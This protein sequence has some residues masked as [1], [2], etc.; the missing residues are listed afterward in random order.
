MGFEATWSLVDIPAD[1]R[2]AAQAAA[3]REGLSVGE[4]L[5]RRILR[6]FSELNAREQA[7]T[8]V[9]LRN[10]V[11]EL[12]GRLDRFEGQS[13]AEPMREALKKL[14][15]GLARL[16]DELV[17]TAGHSAI[18]VSQLSTSLET[19]NVRM[20]EF[21]Q[22]DAES[23]SA[24]ERR[25]SQL[26][27]FVDGMN[28]RHAAETRT[29]ASRMDSLGGTLAESRRLIASD[30]AV[31]ERL[32]DSQAKADSRYSAAFRSLDE[33]IG[34]LS[35]RVEQIG[36]ASS[37]SS[38]AVEHQIAS[39]QMELGKSEARHT[40][41]KQLATA[42]LEKLHGKVDNLQNDMTGMCGALD[43]RV[44]L[45]QQA[46]QSLDVRH[47]EMAHSLTRGLESVGAQLD[48][49]RSDSARI[50]ADVEK[51]IATLETA[52]S[53]DTD[54]NAETHSRFVAIENQLSDLAART[55]AAELA[56][57][58]AL[59]KTD[60]IASQ[61]EQLNLKF[62]TEVE[63]QQQAVEQ[64]RAS[65]VEQTLGALG[66]KLETESKKQ[67]AAIAEL[68]D[69]LLMDLSQAF[70]ERADEEQHKQQDAMTQLQSAFE[71]ALHD[72]GETFESEARKQ[73]EAIAELKASLAVT[74][75][76]SVLLA[77]TDEA[78]ATK[79]GTGTAQTTASGVFGIDST[80]AQPTE[81]ETTATRATA[82]HEEP[83]LEL[84]VLAD[85]H[86]STAE[87]QSEHV[88]QSV[89]EEESEGLTAHEGVVSPSWATAPQAETAFEPA[90][91]TGHQTTAADEP[92]EPVPQAEA[93]PPPFASPEARSHEIPD[94]GGFRPFASASAMAATNASDAPLSGASYLSAARQSLQ[95]AA[96]SNEP[97]KSGKELPGFRFLRSL[98]LAGKQT[99]H[100]TS[101]ALIAGI[102]LV[103]IV[104]VSV[105]VFELTS[106]TAP[107]NNMY[108]SA[109]HDAKPV[110]LSR[111]SHSARMTLTPHLTARLPNQDRVAALANGGD[112]QAQLNIGLRE[113]AKGDNTGAAKWLERA[114]VQGVPPAE[115]RLATLYAS[116]HGVA[117]DRAKAFRWYLEAAQAGNRKAMSNLAVAYAQGD[118][119]PKNPQE[120]GRWFLKAAQL[121]LPDAQFDLAILY[122][123]GLGVPQNLTDAYRW[124]VI[125]AKAG[126][127]ESKDRVD[128]L[129]S[130]LTVEDRAAAEAAAS[131]FKPLPMNVRANEP[132]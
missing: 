80:H 122:E 106:R 33:N 41:E 48:M 110:K 2:D 71:T 64:L 31:V 16:N 120:A 116:G 37:E 94:L 87:I 98:P 29:I 95:T 104:A 7:D 90:S 11:A 13:H 44:L 9:A 76:Q 43:R 102:A 63:R 123:R 83:A 75:Q 12:S 23:R 22:H 56:A 60:A 85:Q 58:A 45:A 51:R 18:Q 107:A 69:G 67:Q 17:R 19:L 34:S 111:T 97:A 5:T 112:A 52:N 81:T 50:A 131:E 46:L 30:R 53:G 10:H 79:S 49:V 117:P 54:A 93:E 70:N 32:E 14:H 78:N 27:E 68:K 59:P 39:L 126:D 129:S 84:A 61:L 66:E 101:Y 65:L 73:Q 128:T 92:S 40:E 99:E 74:P 21:R 105:G 77:S 47:S 119:T 62:A 25:M 89:H 20:D 127:K 35:H 121:G 91:L 15:Q 42:K 103:A 114:A 38:A 36:A 8:F 108:P 6:R 28:L 86:A 132:W 88:S 3:R 130:Q 82:Q 4:W 72:L 24:F 115:Y 109:A 100:T 26:Q 57:S 125:A 55:N 113:L 118:G 124:Y 1:A 96:T